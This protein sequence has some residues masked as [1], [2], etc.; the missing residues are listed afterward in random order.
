MSER[1]VAGFLG[2]NKGRITVLASLAVLAAGLAWMHFLDGGLPA[3]FVVLA[4]SGAF[5]GAWTNGAAIRAVFDYWPALPR[6]I[7]AL[8][9]GYRGLPCT[10]IIKEKKDELVDA[11][12]VELRG[13]LSPDAFEKFLLEELGSPESR[14]ALRRFLRGGRT[15]SAVD[16]VFESEAFARTRRALADAIEKSAAGGLAGRGVESLGRDPELWKAV[17]RGFSN[18][19]EELAADPAR[20]SEFADAVRGR[21]TVFLESDEGRALV[22][23]GIEKS[24]EGAGP[25]AAL[26]DSSHLSY[27]LLDRSRDLV[28]AALDPR[29]QALREGLHRLGAAARSWEPDAETRRFLAG[30]LADAAGAGAASAA[31]ALRDWGPRLRRTARALALRSLRNAP[32]VAER[33]LRFLKGVPVGNGTLF[34]RLAETLSGKTVEIARTR[35]REMDPDDLKDRVLQVSASYLGWLEVYGGVMGAVGGVATSLVI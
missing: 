11:L 35:M 16:V 32:R 17:A 19:L 27:A 18:S 25:A 13:I 21:A 26:L 34:D 12:S 3:R 8:R 15:P 10:G 9:P 31:G 1:A 33:V 2:K 23:R 24:L 7:L 22:A 29:S 30:R 20:L 6:R 4:G 28:S 14:R 5:V